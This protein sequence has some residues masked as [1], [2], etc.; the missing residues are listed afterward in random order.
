MI[1]ATNTST[2]AF[3][4]TKPLQLVFAAS[5]I[6]QLDIAD[7]SVLIITNDFLGAEDVCVR[8][9]T[10]DWDLSAMKIQFSVDR[11]MAERVATDLGVKR[12]FVDSDVGLKR[13]LSLLKTQIIKEPPEIWVYEE[14]I[15][16]YR[17]DLYK[18]SL[19]RRVFKVLG[20]GTHFGDS[21][22]TRG[23]Y[24]R[25]PNQFL[26]KFPKVEVEV[27]QIKLTASETLDQNIEEWAIAFNY[28]NVQPGQTEECALYLTD[29]E[30]HDVGI[31]RLNEFLGDRFIKPHPHIKS[32]IEVP[33]VQMISATA[34][35]E[36]VLM[37]LLANYV[38]VTVFHH[39]SS[40]ERYIDNKRVSFVRL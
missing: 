27:C 21:R 9:R 3:I 39:G 8:A 32:S 33:T 28:T 11:R 13:F 4:V 1:H 19:K 34:P 17:N 23:I 38:Q 14:G 35:A 24:V 22:Y 2:H 12:V 31:I 10:L 26:E 25:N 6:R 20:I 36:L 16:T 15:G 18:D 40:C 29:W 7:Q 30:V 37:D 5:I